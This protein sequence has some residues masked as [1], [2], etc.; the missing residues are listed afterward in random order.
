M[1]RG[2]CVDHLGSTTIDCKA[3]G[4]QQRAE[5]Y[6][7]ILGP[8]VGFGAPFFVKPF[9]HRSSTKGMTGRKG[10]FALCCRC[11]SFWSE[12]EGARESLVL[13]GDDPDGIIA[14]HMRYEMLNRAAEGLEEP[15]TEPGGTETE[16]GA[17][18]LSPTSRVRKLGA[19][20]P[21]EQAVQQPQSI[22]PTVDVP[23]VGADG[24]AYELVCSDCDSVVSEP[25][26]VCPSCGV[27]FDGEQSEDG[28]SQPD[29]TLETTAYRFGRL[30]TYKRGSETAIEDS[31]FGVED[32]P[33]VAALQAELAAKEAALQKA[34]A[35]KE[36]EILERIEKRRRADEELQRK[37]AVAKRVADLKAQ[38]KEVDSEL[39]SKG[40]SVP[41]KDLDP[42]APKVKIQVCPECKNSVF[43][44]ADHCPHCKS[45]MS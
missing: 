39:T 12:D 31:A 17:V 13:Q 18:G 20:T 45:K 30:G 37:A 27:S 22:E 15:A 7:V 33:E 19:D 14:E 38:L 21:K 23:S 5:R 26:T 6:K 28:E 42:S 40:V 32:D 44:P 24:Q 8:T 1:G 3:C 9:L 16:P 34:A 29:G 35:A 4:S 43:M 11:Q 2:Q 10:I 25:A 41:K 36:R